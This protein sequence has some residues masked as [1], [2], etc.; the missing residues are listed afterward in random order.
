MTQPLIITLP[1]SMKI[2]VVKTFV[3]SPE[4]V[5]FAKVSPAKDFHY[6]VL[7]VATLG[8]FNMLQSHVH[9][10]SMIWSTGRVHVGVP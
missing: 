10:H 6:T 4:T 9:N 2:F 3:K 5:K 8:L 7:H 1:Y